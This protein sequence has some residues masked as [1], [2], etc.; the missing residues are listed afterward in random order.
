MMSRYPDPTIWVDDWPLPGLSRSGREKIK[1]ILWKAHA[2]IFKGPFDDYWRYIKHMQEAFSGI[3]GVLFDAKLLT[4]QLLEQELCL[5]LVESGIAGRWFHFPVDETL[6]EVF[7]GY[8]GHSSVWKRFN[9]EVP[10]IFLAETAEW[11]SRLLTE[12][13]EVGALAVGSEKLDPMALRDSYFASFP[14]EKIAILDVCWA[15]DQHYREWKRWMAGEVK[16]GSKADR[17]FRR[18]LTSRK[19]PQDFKATPRP[20]KWQ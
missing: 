3:A 5:L 4:V 8:L 13:A 20:P 16:D 9:E 1:S 2:A 19:R 6:T 7:P 14:D 11:R 18:I 12:S 17:A 10:G 15:A